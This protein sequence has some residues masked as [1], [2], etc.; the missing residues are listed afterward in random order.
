[1]TNSGVGNFTFSHHPFPRSSDVPAGY[2]ISRSGRS[3]VLT[4]Q[5]AGRLVGRAGFLLSLEVS[6]LPMSRNHATAPSGA[7][8]TSSS[9]EF[10]AEYPDYSGT[11]SRPYSLDTTPPNGLGPAMLPA[12]RPGGRLESCESRNVGAPT[13]KLEKHRNPCMQQIFLEAETFGPPLVNDGV[14]E[15][16]RA[17]YDHPTRV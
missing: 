16:E 15:N 12:D 3:Q 5:D 9:S 4:A 2:E 6:E 1:M 13:L 17:S 11:P 14:N 8:C 10:R 7:A